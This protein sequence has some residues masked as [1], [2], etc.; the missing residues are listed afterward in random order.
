MTTMA[1]RKVTEIARS[2]PPKIERRLADLVQMEEFDQ[3][4][5]NHCRTSYWGARDDW[6]QI[7]I[8]C[9]AA[10][11]TRHQHQPDHQPARPTG[12]P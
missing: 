3:G 8:D 6:H 2:L 1:K 11:H 10:A 9:Y 4:D 7:L 5:V 12:R